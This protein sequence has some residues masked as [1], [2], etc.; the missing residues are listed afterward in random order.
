MRHEI[1]L[2]SGAEKVCGASETTGNEG[3]L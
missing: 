3:K 2:L 1:L